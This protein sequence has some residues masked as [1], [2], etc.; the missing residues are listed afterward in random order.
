MRWA[1]AAD[2]DALADRNVIGVT[3]R[4]RRLALYRVDAEYFA[5]S[6]ASPHQG[7]PL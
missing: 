3:C 5:K 2:C 7:A 6:D 1:A 4:G